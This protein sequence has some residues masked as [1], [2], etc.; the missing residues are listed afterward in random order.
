MG[1][2]TVNETDPVVV[3]HD[4]SVIA[5]WYVEDTPAV[6]EAGVGIL[7][8]LRQDGDPLVVFVDQRTATVLALDRAAIERPDP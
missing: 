7:D 8:T 3:H 4:G 5:L 1:S 2:I 6:R